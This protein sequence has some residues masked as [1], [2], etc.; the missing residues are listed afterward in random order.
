LR[1]PPKG[2]FK[3]N[4]AQG[5]E[6]KEVEVSQLPESIREASLAAAKLFL[7]KYDNPLFSVDFGL[8]PDGPRVF[9]INDQIGFPAPNMEQKNLFLQELVTNFAQKLKSCRQLS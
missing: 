6:I 4:V 9:E 8:G 7:E 5:G 2:S 3:A 1:T